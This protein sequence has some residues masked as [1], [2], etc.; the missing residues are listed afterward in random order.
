MKISTIIAP[1][2]LAFCTL[3]FE[4]IFGYHVL[5]TDPSLSVIWDASLRLEGCH[6]QM[7]HKDCR[8]FLLG[9]KLDSAS[10][11]LYTLRLKTT[12]PQKARACTVKI[13]IS[14]C[15]GLAD[16]VYPLH[17]TVA[18]HHSLGTN[19]QVP[20]NVTFR[21]PMW[22]G[23]FE[24]THHG[25]LNNIIPETLRRC[26]VTENLPRHGVVQGSNVT[27]YG[28]N[29]ILHNNRGRKVTLSQSITC[30]ASH[31]Q[32]VVVPN[33]EIVVNVDIPSDIH[34][35]IKS[36]QRSTRRLFR[37]RRGAGSISFTSTRQTEEIFENLPANTEV[38]QLTLNNP[39]HV[40]VKYTL[41]AKLDKRSDAAFQI[42]A[43]TG[44]VTTKRK[45]D[46][47]NMAL[48]TF[49]VTASAGETRPAS[50]TL[51]IMVKDMNDNKPKFEKAEYD[52]T[53]QEDEDLNAYIGRVAASDLDQGRNRRVIYSI[54]ALSP[55]NVFSVSEDGEISLRRGLDRES[56]AEYRFRVVATDSGTLP[57][58]S[59]TQV[60]IT[61]EDVNDLA[62]IFNQTQY[63]AKISENTKTNTEIITVKAIDGDTG[64]NGQVWYGLR[65]SQDRSYFN[66]DSTTGKITLTSEINFADY[67]D[68]YKLRVRAQDRGRP[69][70]SKYCMVT[71]NIVDV[72]DHTPMFSNSKY[73]AVV[74]EDRDI[75]SKILEV[76]A[77]DEDAGENARISYS[78]VTR[79][80]RL[81]FRMNSATGLITLVRPLDFED[82]NVYVFTVK[83]SDHGQPPKYS[84]ASVE[85]TVRD[86]ND[87]KPKFT[88]SLYSKRIS[89]TADIGHVVVAV[90]AHDLDKES[91]LDYSIT[92]G[93]Y[94]NKFRITTRD[95]K[96]II[97]LFQRLSFNERR[98]YLLTVR[99]SD[100]ELSGY[101]KVSVN[102]TDANT[103]VP[104][105]EKS[106][107]DID[108]DEN[109]DVGTAVVRVHATD[110]DDGDNAMITYHFQENS[111]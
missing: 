55:P 103:H 17:I 111:E 51:F 109:V 43:N 90:E 53:V 84:T 68:G 10:G 54:E 65:N 62:P 101:T 52:F 86:V 82:Q 56:K 22:E 4:S 69:P 31:D 102:V 42:N 32:E 26:E 34:D 60:V 8:D 97:T 108:V 41:Q 63:H 29:S 83:A 1:G 48:H 76:K 39:H 110:D 96:G 64:L 93:N 7:H 78:F 13:S 88:K 15:D 75:N 5:I 98:S 14:N 18:P 2:L 24:D 37:H 23:E 71:V 61:V 44:L 104:E 27:P 30:I 74:S 57:Q 46:R 25:L 20:M 106:V 49:R 6:Y 50:C 21:R 73:E 36:H 3:L 11:L 70:K 59:S 99:C 107:Y 89:E 67:P 45:L 19:F 87:N 91:T 40:P 47:E 100:G 77:N 35:S 33:Q 72:N 95:N 58:H 81:P 79:T 94:R 28:G 16:V 92:D 38:I 80:A 105:F 12:H 85:V 9:M 66:I